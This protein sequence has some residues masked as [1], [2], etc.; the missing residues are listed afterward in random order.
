MGLASSVYSQYLLSPIGPR[1]RPVVWNSAAPIISSMGVAESI[2]DD[3][4][5]NRK[6]IELANGST[7]P[8]SAT[9]F[10]G[11]SARRKQ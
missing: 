3:H 10:Y 2:C 4:V 7:S 8:L 9:G 1:S 6:G 5:L 11:F